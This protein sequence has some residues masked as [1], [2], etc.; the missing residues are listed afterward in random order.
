ME[1]ARN[2]EHA[3]PG[4]VPADTV[5]RLGLSPRAPSSTEVATQILADQTA[6]SLTSVRAVSAAREPQSAR[7]GFFTGSFDPPTRAHLAILR[8]LIDHH[9]FDKVVV[10]VNQMNAKTFKAAAS[11]RVDMILAGLGPQYRRRAIVIAE[12]PDGKNPLLHTLR[13]KSALPVH[14]VIGQDSWEAVPPDVQARQEI[15]WVVIP[16][17]DQARQPLPQQDNV[18]V[19]SGLDVG[20]VSST[21]VRGELSEGVFDKAHLDAGVIRYVR[22]NGLYQPLAG[23]ALDAQRVRF[24]DAWSTF[25]RPHG[26][27]PH[28]APA[29]VET[30]SEREWPHHFATHAAKLGDQER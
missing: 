17:G 13:E 24:E 25:A 9:G 7:L 8:E 27:A 14:R 15:K 11:E 23:P 30:Q 18:I 10:V 4:S 5:Q 16:R 21:K 2:A 19:L 3:R 12:P 26:L 22:G 20:A 28:A 6:R 29:F 1:G